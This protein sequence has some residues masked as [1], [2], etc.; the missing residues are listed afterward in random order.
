VRA[1]IRGSSL[2]VAVQTLDSSAH[3]SVDT[4]KLVGSTTQWPSQS[5]VDRFNT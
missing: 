1:A 3:T 4:E 5:D 2:G